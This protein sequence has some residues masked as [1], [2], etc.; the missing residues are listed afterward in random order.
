MAAAK[1]TAN[2]VSIRM[3]FFIVTSIYDNVS[4]AHKKIDFPRKGWVNLNDLFNMSPCKVFPYI[5][6]FGQLE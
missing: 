1:T 3:V 2:P 5:P 4:P 6:I